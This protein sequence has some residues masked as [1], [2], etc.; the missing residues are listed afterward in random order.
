METII[1][2]IAMIDNVKYSLYTT[3]MVEKM[4]Q[5][6][7]CKL[8]NN[9]NIDIV[10]DVSR[11]EEARALAAEHSARLIGD[12]TYE[13]T[14]K[15][16]IVSHENWEQTRVSSIQ[17]GNKLFKV[18]FYLNNV[19]QDINIEAVSVKS[20]YN[21]VKLR[22]GIE[23]NLFMIIYDMTQSVKKKSAIETANLMYKD[24]E[25]VAKLLK[26]TANKVKT[27]EELLPTRTGIQLLLSMIKDSYIGKHIL[28]PAIMVP[29]LGCLIYFNEP[30]NT[31][32]DVIAGK[33]DIDDISM[34]KLL[35]DNL[36][37]VLLLYKE[38]IRR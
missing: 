29:T 14:T 9:T 11:P 19:K 26:Q 27:V 33:E 23:E 37:N 10:A 12:K 20:A 18:L 38:D 5:I 36:K 7:V 3:E 34:M 31:T 16:K 2:Y 32:Q 22:F 15:S 1:N 25:A 30:Y 6:V 17:G 35:L 28:T 4:R 24:K 13:I 21:N 8:S